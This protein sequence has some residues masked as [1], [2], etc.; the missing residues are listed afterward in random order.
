MQLKHTMIIQLSPLLNKPVFL[1]VKVLNTPPPPT[2]SPN[3]V[4]SHQQLI[5]YLWLQYPSVNSHIGILKVKIFKKPQ[6]E[7]FV[8]SVIWNVTPSIQ[9]WTVN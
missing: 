1:K 3:Y 9:H 5:Q 7:F 2:A 4:I 8:I 6:S